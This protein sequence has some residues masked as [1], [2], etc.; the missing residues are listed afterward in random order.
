VSPSP[1]LNLTA[2][3]RSG[4]SRSLFRLS[5]GSGGLPVSTEVSL[6]NDFDPEDGDRTRY[7]TP[8]TGSTLKEIHSLAISLCFI[9]SLNFQKF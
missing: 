8:E 6:P 9:P 3:V 4:Q 5:R 1:G 2:V 7:E